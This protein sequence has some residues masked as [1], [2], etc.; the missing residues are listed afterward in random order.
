MTTDKKDPS[1]VMK[2][3]ICK[4]CGEHFDYRSAGRPPLYCSEACKNKARLDKSGYA[5]VCEICGKSF[6]A[7]QANRLY[8]SKACSGIAKITKS[9][10][11]SKHKK[12]CAVCEKQF[13]TIIPDQQF[14]SSECASNSNRRYNTCQQCG[15]PFWRRNAF[16]MKFCSD[17]CRKNARRQETEE[18]RQNRLVIE[19]TKYQRDCAEC[20]EVFITVYPKKIYC[21]SAC[22]HNANLRMKRE[23]WEKEYTPRTFACKECGNVVSTK[24]GDTRREFCCDTCEAVYYRRK[25]HQTTRHKAFCRE[26]KQRREKQIAAGFVESVSYERLYERDHGICQICGMPVPDDK[27]ADDSWG[28]TIDHIVPLSRGGKHGQSNC[29]LTH[30][31]CNSLKSDT[32]DGF[33]IDWAVKASENPYWM[34]KYTRGISVIY[35]TLPHAGV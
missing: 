2:H 13:E 21:S 33:H 28:G 10:Y 8:C 6:I 7:L 27:F 30:R 31:I 17:E 20:G 32:E 4:V 19:K 14:C 16:R 1:G 11:R 18:R 9:H 29:Q 23:Q 34:K 25:E 24:C 35:S 22:S 26:S 3:C 15:K 5:H 12:I